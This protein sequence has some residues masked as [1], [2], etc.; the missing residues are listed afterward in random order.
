MRDMYFVRYKGRNER[1]Q[2]IYCLEHR[3]IENPSGRDRSDPYSRL[4]SRPDRG[5]RI[6]PNHTVPTG[7]AAWFTVFQAINCLA[8]IVTSLR[9]NKPYTCQRFR[10]HIRG[11]S[12]SRTRTTTR[13]MGLRD[14]KPYTCQRFRLHI[15]GN[16]RS[17]TRTTTRTRTKGLAVQEEEFLSSSRDSSKAYAIL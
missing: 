14:N 3:S 5:T 4:I 1:S 8:R 12:R 9:D 2:A 6:G 17:R 7:R 11:N 15:R 10:L 16:S 13:T